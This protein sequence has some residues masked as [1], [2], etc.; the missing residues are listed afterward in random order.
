MLDLP[1]R[2]VE[3]D[4][5]PARAIEVDDQVVCDAEQ[6]WTERAFRPCAVGDRSPCPEKRATGQ[7]LDVLALLLGEGRTSRL[8]HRLK[9]KENKKLIDKQ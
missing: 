8:H 6:P 5:R 7:I 3:W 9:D 1:C 2:V 4:R